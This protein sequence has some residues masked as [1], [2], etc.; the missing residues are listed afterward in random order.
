[1]LCSYCFFLFHD[2]DLELGMPLFSFWFRKPYTLGCFHT[3][4]LIKY[5]WSCHS[6][7]S[8]TNRKPPLLQLHFQLHFDYKT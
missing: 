1:M 5:E 6:K 3:Y 2:L 7:D 4:P 8:G